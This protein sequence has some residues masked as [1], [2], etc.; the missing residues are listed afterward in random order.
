[1]EIPSLKEVYKDYFTIGAAV[2]HLN[3]YH[4]ENLLKKHFNSL[5][6]ENQMKWEVIHPKPYVYDFGPADEIV[7][8][9]MKNGMKVRG[10]TLVWHNQTPGWVYAGTKDEILARLKEHI[11]E[12]VGHYKGK[13]Y[14]WDVVN[15]ALSDNPNE[16]L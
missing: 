11:K 5:T 12:V 14:A 9:A 10:H 1:M 6:P 8:F 15:E 16:F 4:Y 2:S 3:I 13:V 7:D